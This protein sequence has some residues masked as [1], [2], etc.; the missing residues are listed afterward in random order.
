[1]Q[2]ISSKYAASVS[3]QTTYARRNFMNKQR[4]G[5]AP[6][7]PSDGLLFGADYNPE[8]WPRES[9]P[10]DIRLMQE[11]G[12]NLVT[13]G[14]FS[15]AQ[16]EPAEGQW[17]FAWLDEVLD[18][19][20]AGGI[21]V[22]LATPTA[23]PPPWLGKKYPRT[24]PTDAHGHTLW[25]GSRNQ[26][27][28]SST[29][30]RAAA[31]RITEQLAAR[32][33]DHPALA[34]WHVGNELGQISYDDET[35]CAFRRWLM[36]RHTSLERVNAAWGTTFWSQQYSTWEEILP[37]RSAPYIGN[38]SQELDFK[39]FTSDQLISLY[40]AERDIITRH[41]TVHPVTTNMMGFF[42]G[43]DY[44]KLA[45]ETDFVAND[46]YTDPGDRQSW[47]LGSLTHDLCRGLAGGTP[48]LLMESA[49]SAVNWRPHNVAKDPGALRV[50]ALSAVARGADGVC[51]F[52]FRQSAFGAER[53]HSAVVPL[54]GAETR[55]FREA[56]ALG[57]EMAQLGALAG[58]TSQAKIAILFDWSSW[59]AAES[60]A[61][62]SSRLKVMDQLLAYYQPLLRHG[63]SVEVVHPDSA[64]KRFDLVLLPNL[65]IVGQEQATA[66]EHY[67][68]DG[69]HILVGP[70]S[71]VA[72]EEA[73]L[74]TGRF[75]K[76]LSNV[77][78]VSGEEW[79]PL[80]EPVPLV[81]T[82]P[83]ADAGV[84]DT[85]ATLWSEDLEVHG[86]HT[87]TLA[88]FAGGRLAGQA[89]VTAN[90]WGAGEAWYVGADLPAPALASLVISAVTAAGIEI[91]VPQGL[92]DDVEAVERAGKL[93][94]LNHGPATCSVD[95]PGNHGTTTSITLPPYGA[96][97]L[98][99]KT[100]RV[101]S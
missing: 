28:P 84:P 27:N 70:F 15:W 46:W 61:R 89:A 76:I 22:S 49:T 52:Q 71:A 47:Q 78:G 12:I 13:V 23:S 63:L 62:P 66:L 19:L 90:P 40:R 88:C 14:V 6:S 24:L 8:Q 4:L 95:M 16:L 7:M 10:E 94:L 41:D 29:Q 44:F 73:K 33:S 81:F 5:L 21:R 92:P 64:L 98:S 31:A 75:P 43:L 42:P 59:W 100:N 37:P 79:L 82:S 30:Y 60:A 68:A 32:Y 77:L 1:M 17:N 56:A 3:I 99:Q 55:V 48:W 65:F 87:R 93:F 11:A 2:R 97:V 34:M 67:V 50:D 51:F 45:K 74:A 85:H 54:A 58:T 96:T 18:L 53:F 80:A 101:F 36:D 35:A 25:Y 57:A 9:W 83:D 91:P 20:H 39:R 69:G 26:F 38:P 86:A 72:D